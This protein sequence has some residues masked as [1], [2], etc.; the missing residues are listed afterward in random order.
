[1]HKGPCAMNEPRTQHLPAWRAL[2]QVF[3][4]EMSKR[5]KLYAFQGTIAVLSLVAF[6][7]AGQYFFSKWQHATTS[8]AVQA[9]TAPQDATPRPTSRS[10]QLLKDI[11]IHIS[12]RDENTAA[13]ERALQDE[14]AILLDTPGQ[15][16][17]DLWLNLLDEGDQALWEI[18]GP[19]QF[20][21]VQHRIKV[22]YVLEAH[23]AAQRREQMKDWPL[24]SKPQRVLLNHDSAAVMV[25]SMQQKV[26]Q[27]MV[28]L[29]VLMLGLVIVM[30]TGSVAGI[31][32][33]AR[34][35]QGVLEAWALTPHPPWVLYGGE[36]LSRALCGS[37]IVGAMTGALCLYGHLPAFMVPGP[38]VLAFGMICLVSMWGMLATML[39]HH[40]HG[41]MFGRLALSPAMVT[42]A[43]LFRV[44]VISGFAA[45]LMASELGDQ[46][47]RV[48]PAV[49]SAGMVGVGVLMV[50]S[51]VPIGWVV[52][53][54]IGARRVGLRKL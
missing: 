31:D 18:D 24:S 3:L 32:W 20:H 19:S 14:G 43:M 39:F 5:W 13:I 46:V 11:R 49:L 15:K 41:R 47:M 25:A 16:R 7:E 44:M 22:Q 51:C 35:S 8:R 27:A 36:I 17:G 34:R 2:L 26:N 40:R 38:M 21:V 10:G 6:I 12:T 52:E 29:P 48:A 50:V 53:K 4:I 54:R 30:L 37:A 23:A 45:G 9:I 33:D 1:M 28:Y 42:L